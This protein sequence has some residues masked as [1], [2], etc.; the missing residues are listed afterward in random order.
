MVCKKRRVKN[1]AVSRVYG[2]SA[3]VRRTNNAIENHAM[4]RTNVSLAKRL[5]MAALGLARIHL[6]LSNSSPLSA[7]ERV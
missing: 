1:I 5:N 7:N 3:N 6:I 4:E 2:E